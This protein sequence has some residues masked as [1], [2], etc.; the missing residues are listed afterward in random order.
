M[1]RNGLITMKY[2]PGIRREL[3]SMNTTILTESC[4]LIIA[5]H[6]KDRLLKGKLTDISKGKVPTTYRIKIPKN[7]K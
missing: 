2:I 3:S 7:V 5:H 4:S 6:L 1:I